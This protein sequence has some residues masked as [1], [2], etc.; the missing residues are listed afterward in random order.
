MLL[1][2]IQL[3][4]VGSEFPC[5]IALDQILEMLTISRRLFQRSLQNRYIFYL[6]YILYKI[7]KEYL[8]S[9]G[10]QVGEVDD[11]GILILLD[12]DLFPVYLGIIHEHL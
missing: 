8:I 1:D 5:Q 3:E 12:D 10:F 2:V 4:S 9:C 11:E 6:S 7:L